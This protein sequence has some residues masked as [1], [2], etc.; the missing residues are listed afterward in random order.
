MGSTAKVHRPKGGKSEIIESG[1][2]LQ[3]KSGGKLLLDAGSELY[4]SGLLKV[5]IV[6]VSLAELNAGKTLIAGVAGKSI[7]VLQILN[8]VT[9]AVQ[10]ATAVTVTTTDGATAIVTWAVAAL[11]DGARLNTGSTISNQTIGAGHNTALTAGQGVTAQK[12]GSAATNNTDQK[13]TIYY[14]IS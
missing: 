6:T 11:T 14:T 13:L 12:T 10:T 8:V 3:V 5:A 7:R 1:G 4:S 2:T 9:G